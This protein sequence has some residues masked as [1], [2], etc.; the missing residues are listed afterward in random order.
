MNHTRNRKI[1]SNH[2]NG[3]SRRS[4]S[5]PQKPSDDVY[6]GTS[7]H[8]K[9]NSSQDLAC[10][11]LQSG[12]GDVSN[13]ASK[14]SQSSSLTFAQPLHRSKFSN[15]PTQI[16]AQDGPKSPSTPPRTPKK[17]SEE[18][19]QN[20][21]KSAIPLALKQLKSYNCNGLGYWENFES[22]RLPG[23]HHR[24]L[25]KRKDETN[26]HEQHQTDKGHGDKTALKKKKKTTCKTNG[27]KEKSQALSSRTRKRSTRKRV[28]SKTERDGPSFPTMVASEK[29]DGETTIPAHFFAV[30]D[31]VF[32]ESHAWSYVNNSG[33]IGWIQK[34]Y[35]SDDGDRVY[36]VKYPALNRTE[37]M[38]MAEF[39]SLYS[40]D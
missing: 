12:T 2:S 10:K 39:I 13:N 23:N 30:A 24:C 40:F 29:A 8:P 25:R 11:S 6:A 18:E 15:V 7:S 14:S 33:G 19:R 35:I 1:H 16:S 3:G 27:G 28:E 5:L 26:K 4:L 38:I 32:V 37:K 34:A 31:L 21:N 9:I 17:S 20:K 22:K 36:D